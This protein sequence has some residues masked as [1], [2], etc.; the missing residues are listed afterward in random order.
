M[1]GCCY[2]VLLAICLLPVSCEVSVLWQNRWNG[3]HIVFTVN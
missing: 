3:N 2:N 1:F